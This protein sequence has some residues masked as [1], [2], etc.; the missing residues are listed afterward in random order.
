[1]NKTVD[2]RFE[3]VIHKSTG[4]LAAFSRDLEGLLVHGRTEDEIR[5]RTPAAIRSILEAQG[6][7]VISINEVDEDDLPESF[8]PLNVSRYNAHL[9]AVA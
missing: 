3:F 5:E 4:L 1:M 9:A 8:K 7:E 2:I 6:N